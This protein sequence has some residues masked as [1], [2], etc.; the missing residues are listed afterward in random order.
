L[1]LLSPDENRA[2]GENI[3]ETAAGPGRATRT[4]Y[5]FG[6]S[7]LSSLGLGGGSF[8]VD[9]DAQPIERFVVQKPLHRVL[10]FIGRDIDDVVN[11]RIVK[12]QVIGYY[13][14]HK[15]VERACE[16]TDLE[17]AWNAR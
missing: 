6:M 12:N 8:G 5:N 2:G 3:K 10:A 7:G 14:L 1:G 11:D 16:V 13:K 4:C 9:L 15:Q 17:R